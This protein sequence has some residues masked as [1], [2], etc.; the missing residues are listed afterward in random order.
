LTIAEY[1]V[2]FESDV[3]LRTGRT[4][5]IRPVRPED[6]E[7][8]IA[9]YARL[10]PESL[11]ARFFAVCRPEVAAAASP[12]TV[13]YDREFG[14][15]AELGGEIAGVA[16]YFTSRTS[17]N[18]AEVAFAIS[19]TVQGCGAATKLLETLAAAARDHG[20]DRFVAEVLPDNQRMLDVFL[21]TG[22]DVVRRSEEGLIHL[23]FPITPTTASAEQTARR[24]QIAAYASM[25]AVFA[26]QS[27]AVIGASRRP[28]QL[29]REIV[30]NLRASGYV[31]DLYV[32]NPHAAE[33]EGIRAH[34]SLRDIPEPVE[35]AI[36]AV[37]AD[38]VEGA[39]DDCIA[40]GVAAVVVITAGFAEVGEEGRKREAALLEKIRRAGIRMVGPNCMGVINTDPNVRMHGTFSAIFPPAGNVAM[41]SQ[42]GALGLSVLDY[43]KALN[44]GFST[45]VS[46]GNKADVSGN[47]LIQ[48][49]AE[50]PNTDVILL[51]LESF[52]N[53]R[54]FGEI[55]RRVGRTKPIVAVKAGRSQAG[56][57]AASSHTGALATSDA[58]VDDLFRQSG[59]IRT[60]T[61][62]E[63]FDVAAL[64]ANQPLPKGRRVAIL[65]NAGGPGILAADACE[66]NGLELG[67]LDNYTVTSLR[68]FLPAAASVANPIDMIASASPEHYRRSLEL[69]L[70]DPGI[71]AVVVIY[72]PVLP[73][74]APDVAAAIRGAAGVSQDKTILATF[75]SA[76]GVPAPLAPVPAFAFP[77]RAVNALAQV[78]KYS[79]WRSKPAGANVPF[80]L[81][82]TE[83]RSVVDGACSTGGRWLHPVEVD[84]V[85]RAA[86]IGAPTTVLAMSTE[87]AMD[88]ARSVGF[89]VVL[90]AYGPKLLHKSDVGGVRLGLAHEYAVASAYEDLASSLGDAMTGAIIQPMI[91]GGVEMMLGATDQQSF[92]HVI[93]CGAGGVLVELLGDV[94]FRVHPLTDRDAR[95]MLEQ[96]RCTKLLR[97]YRGKP[98]ADADALRESILRLSALLDICPEIREI[99]LNPLKVMEHGVMAVDARIRVEPIVTAAASRRIAY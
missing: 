95:E 61:L 85:M 59:I 42:S 93:A 68:A 14:A 69:L 54:K 28:G 76:A 13:D 30:H 7:R 15:V 52:G 81:D 72:I 83:L 66:A 40:A 10:S 89:P 16:H 35:L 62:E 37:P 67:Q 79:E 17:R 94:A 47:D 22:F 11:H 29:G 19:D 50:D 38:L 64:L 46:V 24:S 97:G 74:D 82:V 36:I 58:I 56:A 21:G 27:I 51:Y 34:A 43:A 77:E 39:L 55:A 78:T 63:M 25:R 90:K 99:D 20:I 91:S 80:D 26:P 32:V 44:I 73:T 88:A 2:R 18:V 1:P 98:A 84:A 86:G 60:G 96:I 57:K 41:S 5:H 87:A 49:W 70:A 23:E 12:S 6:C 45:F 9:F 75:M 53:P 4:V 33:V 31:G 48:Y 71:D 3:V 65:T 8:L 92:G